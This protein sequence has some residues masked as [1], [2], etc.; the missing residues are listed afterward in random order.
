MTWKGNEPMS[1]EDFVEV[2]WWPLIFF[3]L[4]FV[5]FCT[6]LTLAVIGLFHLLS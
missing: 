4:L 1:E 2:T 3:L 5:T 6:L